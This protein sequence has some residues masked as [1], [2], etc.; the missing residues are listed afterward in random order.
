MVLVLLGS[1]LAACVYGGLQTRRLFSKRVGGPGS[2]RRRL[3]SAP[4]P[5]SSAEPSVEL[6]SDL[7]L[8]SQR[9][10][11]RESRGHRAQVLLDEPEEGEP[12]ADEQRGSTPR[13]FDDPRI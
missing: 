9:R 6:G 10:S 2:V 13:V 7:P 12:V 8:G 5:S 3:Q 11:R 4:A 1:L